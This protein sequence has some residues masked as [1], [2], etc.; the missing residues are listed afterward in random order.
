MKE[1]GSVRKR[2]CAWRW[3]GGGGGGGQWECEKKDV[4]V[5]VGGRGGGVGGVEDERSKTAKMNVSQ[6]FVK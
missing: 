2:M 3:G 5:C 1:S 4:C 6:D